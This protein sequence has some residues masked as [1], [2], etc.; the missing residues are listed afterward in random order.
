VGGLIDGGAPVA[1]RHPDGGSCDL[2]ETD[3]DGRLIV[4]AVDVPVM[5]EHGFVVAGDEA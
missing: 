4:P 1:M 3:A 2:Y 5:I